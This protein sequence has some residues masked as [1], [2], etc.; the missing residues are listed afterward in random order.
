MVHLMRG[1]H[2]PDLIR[3]QKASFDGAEML[4]HLA[5]NE[6]T[7]APSPDALEPVSSPDSP[8]GSD[9]TPTTCRRSATLGTV[10]ITVALR[11]RYLRPSPTSI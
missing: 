5:G 4:Q 2:V 9:L 8:R 1:L 6:A 11:Y 3:K 10:A 7:E